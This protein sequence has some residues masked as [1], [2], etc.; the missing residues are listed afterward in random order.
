[1]RL[2][3]DDIFDDI[4][5]LMGLNFP[6]VLTTT[7][8]TGSYSWA[9]VLNQNQRLFSP[10]PTVVPQ[11]ERGILSFIAWDVNPPSPCAMNYALEIQR[12]LGRDFSFE[13]SYI[14][15]QGRKLV[16][17][18][19][20]DQPTVTVNDPTKRG[21]QAP[22]VRT[23]PFRQYSKIFQAA[24]V[25]NSNFDGM[26]LRVRKRPTYGLGFAASYELSKSLD[27]N[28]SFF[29]SDGETGIY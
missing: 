13:V 23:F 22:N 24:F 16:V 17:T 9:T 29:G 18:L 27:D 26:V 14:G 6:P 20:P 15:S 3:Y 11:G 12:Q 5:T 25:S 19:D 10:D 8:P 7:L 2:S 21:D 28:S 4:P 1:F